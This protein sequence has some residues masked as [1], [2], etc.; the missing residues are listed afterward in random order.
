M[1]SRSTKRSSI[2]SCRHKHVSAAGCD[3]RPLEALFDDC[4]DRHQSESTRSSRAQPRLQYVERDVMRM[5]NDDCRTVTTGMGFGLAKS[6]AHVIG[7]LLIVEK[8]IARYR[9][10]T[11]LLRHVC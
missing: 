8:H 1:A 4:A 2:A 11:R 9:R 7:R 3:C 10:D 5:P 6:R